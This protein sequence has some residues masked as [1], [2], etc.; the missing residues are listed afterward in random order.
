MKRPMAQRE[1]STRKLG[2]IDVLRQVLFSFIK[3]TLFHSFGQ[4]LC[5]EVCLE[6]ESNFMCQLPVPLTSSSSL[7]DQSLLC[8]C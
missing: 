2:N 1:G 8:L 7:A 5:Y 4:P 3:I 6:R